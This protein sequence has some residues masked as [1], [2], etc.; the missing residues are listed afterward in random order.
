MS[1]GQII[2]GALMS[3]DEGLTILGGEP[4]DQRP[5]VAT[6]ARRAQEVGLGVICFTGFIYRDLR[7]D[8][9]ATAVLDHV[10]L[11]VDGPYDQQVP[12]RGRALVGSTN[13]E[14]HQL[15]SRYAGYDPTATRNRVELR[16]GRDG[17]IQTAGFLT[18][19]A[20]QSLAG[21]IDTRRV[22]R[23]PADHPPV[24]DGE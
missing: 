19:T 22:M 1:V 9:I 16:I 2:D 14:F 15:T 5:A 4:F 3:G 10:D 23:Q 17:T 13:Q 7:Q 18:E 11:L 21:A 12:E 24:Q 8:P 20:V 6:L